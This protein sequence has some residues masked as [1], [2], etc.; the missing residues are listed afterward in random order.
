MARKIL[1]CRECP[2][3]IK[4]TI[5]L[6]A[7]TEEELLDAAVQHGV[8]SH[9]YRDAAELRSKLRGAIKEETICA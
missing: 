6:S 4:C 3:D 5:A 8:N 9:G 1:D 2:S 7:D